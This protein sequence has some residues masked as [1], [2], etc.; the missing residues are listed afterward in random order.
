[1]TA[2]RE[3]TIPVQ[4]DLPAALTADDIG[5]RGNLAEDLRL[6]WIID[7]VR[8]HRISAGRGAELAAIGKLDFLRLLG[9]HGVPAIDLTSEELDQELLLLD[10]VVDSK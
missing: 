4:V 2:A 9:K 5:F 10:T 6:L 1:M 3:K 8:R 7:Q